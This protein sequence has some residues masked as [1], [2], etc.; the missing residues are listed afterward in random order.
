ML[1][2]SE[3]LRDAFLVS[4]SP[5][6]ILIQTEDTEDESN[7]DKI[8]FYIGNYNESAFTAHTDLP[9]G[10]SQMEIF[11]INTDSVITNYLTYG[12]CAYVSMKFKLSN[13]TSFPDS[14]YLDVRTEETSSVSKLT[15][16]LDLTDSSI[17]SQI[18]GDGIRLYFRVTTLGLSK[19]SWLYF[20]YTGACVADYSISEVQVSLSDTA[21]T[22]DD[23]YVNNAVP[24]LGE[25]IA[26][27]GIDIGDVIYKKGDD[28]IADVT[29]ENLE[30]ES[31]SQVESLSSGENLKFGACEAST[32][33]F[34]VR[35][36]T[37]NWKDR[38]IRP[39]VCIWD[40]P[41][42]VSKVNWF[43]GSKDKSTGKMKSPSESM[44]DGYTNSSL[45]WDMATFE[46]GL[47]PNLNFWEFGQQG[48]PVLAWRMKIKFTVSNY[49][50][51]PY[52][53]KFYLKLLY[54]GD[55]SRDF[56][57]WDGTPNT[58]L[59]DDTQ[60]D[61][62][63]FY[64]WIPIDTVPSVNDHFQDL[65]EVSRLQYR[66]YD[67]NDQRYTSS[68][69]TFDYTVEVKEVQFN[70]CDAIYWDDFPEWDVEDC[71]DYNG[72]SL[73]EYKMNQTG[74]IPMGR[75]KV[76][77]IK[78]NHK[79]SSQRL[80]LTGYDDLI[81]LNQNAGDWCTMYMYAVNTKQYLPRYD[82]EYARQIFSS[83]WNIMSYLGIDK[84]SNYEE[85]VLATTSMGNFTASNYT[86]DMQDS[87]NVTI[88]LFVETVSS[89]IDVT[90][91][92][93][94]DIEHDYD[95][96]ELEMYIDSYFDH[97]DK[98]AR[99][100]YNQAEIY[101][102]ETLEGGDTNKFV[103]NN[104]DYFMLSPDCVSFNIYAPL[105][106]D[107]NGSD[108]NRLAQSYKLSRVEKSYDLVNASTRLFYYNFGTRELATYDSSIQA[109]DVVRSILEPTGCFL[110]IDRFGLPAFKY[111]TKA[112]LYPSNTL[113]PADNLYPRGLDGGT[114]AT[115]YYISADS[116]DYSVKNIGKIQIVKK[117]FDSSD[118]SI[119]EW[120]YVGDQRNP[121]TYLIDDN[122]FYCNEKS[123]YEYGSQPEIE[124][125]LANMY[126]R[127]NNMGYT[128][129]EV[130][131]V[132][133]PWLEVGDRIG[134]MTVTGGIESFIFRR[135]YKGIVAPKDMIVSQGDEYIEAV[136]DY[137]YKEWS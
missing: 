100:V 38:Y 3:E 17:A 120:E 11:V 63:T 19:L 103:V 10:G 123:E 75:F 50:T 87:G 15:Y 124:T 42:S 129:S 79:G 121:N 102:E 36:R 65:Y 130:K 33:E 132:G 88:R 85:T 108:V 5:K 137:G 51:R 43:L 14:L 90:K 8:N 105:W 82:Y 64:G 72:V 28:T 18:T 1:K 53:I 84:R 135:T 98:Y 113:Y 112:G 66:L 96:E 35:D 4:S 89:N 69:G 99:G 76:T 6:S 7:Y 26:R 62:V 49:T 56:W 107:Y 30:I 117:T 2:I 95:L 39:Y 31:Y 93:V 127:I 94:V 20:R 27:Q 81:K 101:I 122:I 12:M 73:D 133:M 116:E 59:I 60:N 114:I 48:K 52:K 23:L 16:T 109:R 71:I 41:F 58:F 29:N 78:K 40:E 131:M 125:M 77:N 61:F 54:N 46:H 45:S 118:K 57:G 128:P 32:C 80:T 92:Y 47:A 37:D 86:L 91:P 44:T 106:T 25:S 24:Y 83:Y 126:S 119:V 134:I 67:E 70:L 104:H 110:H 136:K 111:C 13:I 34:V 55:Q 21:F 68:A 9:S 97:I 74:N 22:Y 115:G